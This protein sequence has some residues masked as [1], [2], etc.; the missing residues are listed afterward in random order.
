MK[1]IEIKKFKISRFILGGNPFSGFSHQSEEMDM[2]MKRYFT[3]YRIKETLR[4]AEINGIN[5]F[6]GRGDHHIIRILLE[7]WGEG[8]KIQWIAQTCPEFRT[9]ELSIDIILRNNPIGC[10][11]HGGYVD[12]LFLNN[13]I[14]SVIPLIERIKKQNI[15]AGIAAHIPEIFLWAEK[16]LDVD[17]YMSSYYNP[18]MRKETPEKSLLQKERFSDEDREK[19]IDIIKK[20][21]KPVIH[22]KIMAAGRKK[23][24]EAISFLSKNAREN[25]MVCI[26][27]YTEE[28]KNMISENIELM[29]KF[30]FL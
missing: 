23:P 14:E 9:Q 22:Y 5:T 13:K 2:K 20:L 8:G 3:S 12:Y 10:Y 6:I 21:R 1:Y 15:L 29:K 19:M 30:G 7:Y 26:G 16:N 11:I 25:D 18:F 28:K 17:F 24:E 27:I 4:E